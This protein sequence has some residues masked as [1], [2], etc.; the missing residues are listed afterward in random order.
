MKVIHI[1][2]L[3]L[4]KVSNKKNLKLDFFSVSFFLFFNSTSCMLDLTTDF[5]KAEI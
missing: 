3:Y 1:E 4:H 2:E 5:N